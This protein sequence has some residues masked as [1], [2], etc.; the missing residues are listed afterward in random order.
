MVLFPKFPSFLLFVFTYN[1]T[2]RK[3]FH[4]LVFF[5]SKFSVMVG[6]VILCNL[7]PEL[8]RWI[9]NFYPLI[10][11]YVCGVTYP[12]LVAVVNFRVGVCRWSCSWALWLV[13]W[14]SLP[15]FL[16]GPEMYSFVVWCILMVYGFQIK[17]TSGTFS[18]KYTFRCLQIDL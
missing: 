13:G 3:Q 14:N 15:C 17:L 4:L 7:K 10:F 12:V 11:V 2:G 1:T 9:W 5:E 16:W 18:R 8:R 6:W